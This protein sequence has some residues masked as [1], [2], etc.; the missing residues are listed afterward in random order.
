MPLVVLVFFWRRPGHLFFTFV[1]PILPIIYLWDAAVSCLRTRTS[2][3][4]LTLLEDDELSNS[5]EFSSGIEPLSK[6][7]DL[8]WF[9]AFKKT[10]PHMQ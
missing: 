5:W 9:A 10:K 1:V 3:E 8:S 7:Y 4:I 2:E 6:S